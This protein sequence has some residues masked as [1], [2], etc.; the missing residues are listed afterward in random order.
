MFRHKLKVIVKKFR[1]IIVYFNKHCSLKK[2]FKLFGK[3]PL[4]FVSK[5]LNLNQKTVINENSVYMLHN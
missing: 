3:N 1:F 4:K 5:S 2:I